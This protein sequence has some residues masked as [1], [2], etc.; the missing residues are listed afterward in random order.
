MKVKRFLWVFTVKYNIS[1]VQ[2]IRLKFVKFRELKCYS[3]EQELG[4]EEKTG[5][6][7]RKK[8]SPYVWGRKMLIMY[9]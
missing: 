8:G 2:K 4:N 6:H 1:E 5:E 7:F 9:K 3:W